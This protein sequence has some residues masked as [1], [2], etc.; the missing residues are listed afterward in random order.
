[1]KGLNGFS[2]IKYMREN[3]LQKRGAQVKEDVSQKNIRVIP[4]VFEA[5]GG[6]VF[7]NTLLSSPS[8]HYKSVK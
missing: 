6:L 4:E 2:Y 3:S 8:Q 7:H 5:S 1:M